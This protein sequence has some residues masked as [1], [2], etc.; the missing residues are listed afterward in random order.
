MS[1]T[2]TIIVGGVCACLAG[3]A[4]YFFAG[5][6]TTPEDA[7]KYDLKGID[8]VKE[9]KYDKAIDSY[10]DAIDLKQDPTLYYNRGVAYM[11]KG[12]FENAVKDFTTAIGLQ[13][14]NFPALNNR[15][16]SYRSMGKYD[17]AIADYTAEIGMNPGYSG[18]W[19]GRGSCYRAKSDIKNAI[20]DYR[21][22]ASLGD[23][24]AAKIADDLAK[25]K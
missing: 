1:K 23:K 7:M 5:S 17:E 14:S 20:S 18:A 3:A 19:N 12:D 10:D 13:P 25:E 15:A 11:N 6:K 2:K 8:Y 21:K 22:A 24:G 4:F 9:G 16:V